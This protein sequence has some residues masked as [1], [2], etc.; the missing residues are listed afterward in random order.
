MKQV[1][2]FLFFSL[3]LS[4]TYSQNYDPNSFAGPGIIQGTVLDSVSGQPMEFASVELYQKGSADPYGPLG[5]EFFTPQVIMRLQTDTIFADSVKQI[6]VKAAENAKPRLVTGTITNQK[7]K[8]LLENLQIGDYLVK[9]SS[10][11]FKELSYDV[12]ITYNQTASFL[13][14]CRLSKESIILGEVEVVEKAP[15]YESQIDKVIFNAEKDASNESGTGTDVLRKVPMVT[16]DHEGNVQLRG[17]GNIKILINGKPSALFNNNL[18][19]ALKMIPANQIKKVEVITSPSAKYD[20]E[21]T[22]GIINI[23]TKKKDVEGVYASVNL[24][25]DSQNPSTNLNYNQKKGRLNGYANVG[26]SGNFPRDF[27]NTFYRRD[28]INGY[29]RI[30]SQSAIS[31]QK[32]NGVYGQGGVEYT[33]NEKNSI[34]SSVTFNSFGSVFDSE[35][36]IQFTDSLMGINQIYN[37]TTE[38]NFVHSN[39][40]WSTDYMRT[41][42]GEGHELMLAFQ[43]T[44]QVTDQIYNNIQSGND[45][46]L[47][48]SEKSKN[49]GDNNEYTLQLDYTLPIGEKYKIEAGGKTILRNLKSIYSVSDLESQIIFADFSDNFDYI[50]N[51]YA[52]YASV[53]STWFKKYELITGI[54]YEGTQIDGSYESGLEG[55]S[56]A[57]ENYVPNLVLS[58]KISNFS[59][60][61][62]TL[63]NRIQRP[64]MYYLNPFVNSTD[65]LNVSKGNPGLSPENTFNYELGYSTFINTLMINAS[66]FYKNTTDLISDIVSVDTSGVSYTTYENIGF[67][68]S[69]G[70]NIFINYRIGEIY[71][72]NAGLN[73]Y[74]D[75]MTFGETTNTGLSYNGN[76]GFFANYKNGIK[77]SFYSFFNSPRLSLQGETNGFIFTMFGL[78]KEI[79][80]KKGSIGISIRNPFSGYL[81]FTSDTQGEGFAQKTDYKIP[82]R[83]VGF[84]FT[85]SIGKM[86]FISQSK[87]SRRGV[88]N[89]D[90]KAGEGGQGGAGGV[91]AGGGAQ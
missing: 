81:N 3:L 10:L 60:I 38:G 48:Y 79:F 1:F 36:D 29:E 26:Y 33:L 71:S 87:R 76:V 80:K 57:Y 35:S 55:F 4:L 2:A 9:I 50:Q 68:K 54:R 43:L 18:K 85:Y 37:R 63:S 8:F 30:L 84:T 25:M 6:M 16:V 20:A 77:I 11:G 59:S 73:I 31:S 12:S 70:S 66:V 52:G 74:H 27:T 64:S 14:D 78:G 89:D 21:G 15:L 61:K 56:N 45:S 91:G 58:R 88:E 40:D 39:I 24:S 47:N 32:Y 49:E 28:N 65:K 75:E 90:V 69:I 34:N 62:F 67:G 17:S 13:R 22:A 5:K 7:G 41:F 82:F 19:E 53:K 86:D 42:K 51:V 83:S 46:T 72:M 23:I 44:N